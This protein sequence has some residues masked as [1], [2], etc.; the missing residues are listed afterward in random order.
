M[1]WNLPP[2]MSGGPDLPAIFDAG[3]VNLL[4]YDVIHDLTF[5]HHKGKQQI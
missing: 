1:E 3:T 2:L 4:Y 5:I